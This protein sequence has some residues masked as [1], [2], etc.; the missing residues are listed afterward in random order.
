MCGDGGFNMLMCE[1]L[2]AVHHKLP[3]KV[4]V[5]NN[6]AFGL[7]TLEAESVG[8]PPF[9]EAIKFPNPDFAALA[10]ACGGHGFKAAKPGEL[11]RRSAKRSMS[12]DRRS[13]IASWPP[14]IAQPAPYQP[15]DGR[16]LC[17]GQDQGNGIGRNRTVTTSRFAAIVS[18][19]WAAGTCAIN[20][21]NTSKRL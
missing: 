3:I 11:R 4:I 13:S 2:T 16:A 8:L 17:H 5:Y 6:S 1:F 18:I 9:M 15:G 21:R 20:R 14:M 19:V 10:R 7:I 12:M